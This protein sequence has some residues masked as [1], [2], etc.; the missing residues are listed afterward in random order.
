MHPRTRFKAMRPSH[1]LKSADSL[2]HRSTAHRTAPRLATPYCCRLACCLHA[3]VDLLCCLV[4]GFFYCSTSRHTTLHH[5]LSR[6]SAARHGAK[7]R[8][9]A[10]RGAAC[11]GGARQGRGA[12][13]RGRTFQ[14]TVSYHSQNFKLRVSNSRSVAY[15]DFKMPFESSNIPGS[16][17]N[18]PDLTLENW[19]QAK[20]DQVKLPHANRRQARPRG[21]R[22]FL[23]E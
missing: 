20:S 6:R 9:A 1:P 15:V 11:G 17:P 8:C 22:G 10:W 23:F 12:V 3:F 14:A 2:C 19:V 16:G 21:M 13:K 7:R 4:C 5:G 18:F